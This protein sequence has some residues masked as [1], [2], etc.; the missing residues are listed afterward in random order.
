MAVAD[1]VASPRPLG[2]RN[3]SKLVC[4]RGSAVDLGGAAGPSLVL[5]AYAPRSHDVVDL[6]G[7]CR[8][9]EPPLD[10]VAVALRDLLDRAGV[11]PYDEQTF[12]GDLRH[13]VL[14]STTWAPSW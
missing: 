1:C 5:G 2:Y 11:V 10:D 8:I 7:G 9:A 13:A 4:A 12:T 14:A 6:T 3:R